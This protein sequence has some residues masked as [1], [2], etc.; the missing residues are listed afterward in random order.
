MTSLAQFKVSKIAAK[1]FNLLSA[2]FIHSWA[3]R[4][5]NGKLSKVIISSLTSRAR[6]GKKLQRPNV[7]TLSIK[8]TA[9]ASFLAMLFYYSAA[10]GQGKLLDLYVCKDEASADA[11]KK[12]CKI[13]KNVKRSY[14]ANKE[15]R[16]VVEVNYND[17]A[18]TS[19]RLQSNCMVF[20]ERNW[21]CS[22][23]SSGNYNPKKKF[24]MANGVV[25]KNELVKDTSTSGDVYLNTSYCAKTN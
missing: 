14:K 16:S 3:T 23:D 18:N 1:N 11:C 22:Y 19:T 21:D 20:D 8:N 6:K 17:K 5:C 24:K 4:S 13:K 9:S 25:T 15:E 10:F 7:L 12:G 2:W